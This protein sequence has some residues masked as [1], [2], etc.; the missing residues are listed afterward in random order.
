MFKK[1]FLGVLLLASIA[2]V[3]FYAFDIASEKNNYI[4]ELVFS[5]EDGKVLIVS[6]PDEVNF[7][8]I[9]DFENAPAMNLMMALNDSIYK[10]GYFSAN[11]DHMLLVAELNWNNDLIKSL[12]KGKTAELRDDQSFSID[13]YEGKYYKSKL[14]LSKGEIEQNGSSETEFE[15]DKKAS[16]SLFIFEKK[17]IT[18]QTDIYFK[19]DGRVNF[20]TK[21]TAIDQGTQIQDE[22][23]FAELISH[24]I[25]S[26][27]FYERDFYAAL[28]P[29]FTQSP[30]YRWLLNGFT[31]VEY[32]G[33]IAIISDFIGGQDPVLVLNDINQTIDTNRFTNQLTADFPSQG[34]SYT[35]KYLENLV[36]IAE[37]TSTCDKILADYKLGN[38][39][40]SSTKERHRYFGELPRS[41]SERC[42]N[43]TSSYSK[44]LYHGKLMETHTGISAP[45]EKKQLS[46]SIN[47][48]CGFDIKDFTVLPG[49]GNVV[50]LG[51]KNEIACF[52][53]GKLKW[54]KELDEKVIGS[55]QIIDLHYTKENFVLI[56][57]ASKIYVWDLNGKAATG[58]PVSM[59]K[60]AVNQ[61][62]FY[63]WKEKSYFLIA[64]ENNQVIKYN[65]KGGELNIFKSDHSI[66]E[67]I[68]VWVSQ[69]R[70][71]AGFA[72]STKF[73][74][75]E[76][77]KRK[78]LRSFEILP[79]STTIKTSNQLFRYA[80]TT[81]KL[82]RID[83][84]GRRDAID[85]YP[86]GEIISIADENATTTIVVK[87]GNR[88]QLLNE[89]GVS[90]GE[91]QLSFNEV[92]DIYIQTTNSG[93]TYIC[94]IDGLENNVYLYG[95][96]GSKLGAKALE[97]QTKVHFQNVGSSNCI[98][99]VVDQ[100]VIQYIE[101]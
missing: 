40:A 87:T 82:M 41:V 81:D 13:G 10:T 6:R 99:T 19:G 54:K 17:E 59:D 73:T 93:K 66:T 38:T 76:I 16:A 95:T 43:E 67:Q 80:I 77:E 35:V 42:V 47:L 85:T 90:F 24:N 45:V 86:N 2:W 48:S 72:N 34:Q 91:I 101:D 30:M 78:A 4:P 3:L 36:V 53:Q 1:I 94:I 60:S 18:S 97:G 52:S 46:A 63:R 28:D 71:F 31:I 25:S 69:S 75:F 39:I 21:N 56:N 92:E 83:Q 7:S 62:Q 49:K 84:K 74:M 57:T 23:I 100:F 33:E 8:A 11:R 27:H 61:V 20:I 26:Y 44:S 51:K 70:L 58:F 5:S 14:Y 12:F 55:L 79:R 88:I 9:R 37:K 29:T 50:V 96:D 15:F 65:A 22:P 89:E 32:D 64:N 98:T 68:D